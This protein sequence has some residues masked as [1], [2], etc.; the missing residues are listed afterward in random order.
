M[1]LIKSI[2]MLGNS[3]SG[4]ENNSSSEF[5]ETSGQSSID[6]DNQEQCFG[7]GRRRTNTVIF[8]DVNVFSGGCGCG[9]LSCF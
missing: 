6:S 7:W 4:L 3:F 9:G 2:S 5:V 8:G 1:T